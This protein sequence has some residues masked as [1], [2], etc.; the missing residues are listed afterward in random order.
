MATFVIA[1]IS[2]AKYIRQNYSGTHDN[3]EDQPH[4]LKN[5]NEA[6]M[7]PRIFT[8]FWA[9]FLLTALIHAQL[10]TARHSIC[11]HQ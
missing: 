6:R 4:Q 9:G 2:V 10:N 1:D 3:C 8:Q 11:Y 5:E 7:I